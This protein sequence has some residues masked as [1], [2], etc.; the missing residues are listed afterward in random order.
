MPDAAALLVVDRDPRLVM[1]LGDKLRRD[2]Y[3]VSRATTG[4]EALHALD[5]GWPDL[6]ILELELPDMSGHALADRIKERADIPILVLSAVTSVESKVESLRHH[7]EDYVTKPFHY[8]E[9]HARIERILSRT[10]ERMPSRELVLGPDL[11]I[12]LSRRQAVVR[13]EVVQLSLIESRLLAVL[14]ARLNTSVSTDE[15]R[16]RVWGAADDADPASVWVSVRRLRQKLE[17]DADKPRYLITS[18]RA[19]YML[20]VDGPA[21]A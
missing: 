5:E 15:L 19:G 13:G 3:V 6:V 4:K 16:R 1:L 21:E 8:P 20:R 7:A 17:P 10:R 2:G 14:S 12:R 11:S 9:L 18:G